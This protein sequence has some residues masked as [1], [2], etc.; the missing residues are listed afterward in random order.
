MNISLVGIKALTAC[1]IVH[2]EF[3]DNCAAENF[4]P[5]EHKTA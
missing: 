5:P 4:F 3:N 1:A 2:E